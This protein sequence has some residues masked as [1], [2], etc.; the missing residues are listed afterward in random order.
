MDDHHGPWSNIPATPTQAEPQ[1]VRRTRST[2]G[3]LIWLMVMVLVGAGL[4]LAPRLLPV[5]ARRVDW[6]EA[7]RIFA[8]LVL[9][10][11]S[12]TYLRRIDLAQT[13]RMAA[14]WLVIVGVIMAGYALRGDVAQLGREAQLMLNPTAAQNLGPKQ[15][16]LGR[17]ADQAFHVKGAVNGSPTQFMI[18]TGATDIVLA[19]DDAARA[20]I[21]VRDADFKTAY[22]TANGVGM[23]ARV[24]VKS[25]EVGPYRLKDVPVS[26]NKAA[27]DTSVLGL[28]FIN[29]MERVVIQDDRMILVRH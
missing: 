11:S 7:S 18:D 23:G 3:L 13:A 29:R 27:M 2:I 26:I 19:P 10:S 16:V 8:I 1:P 5:E 28:A 4:L 9:L 17:Y 21:V 25:L 24:I 15:W 20:G 22:G 14:I 12:L 6:V